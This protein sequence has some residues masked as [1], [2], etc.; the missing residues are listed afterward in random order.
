M[1]RNVA[2]ATF[3]RF[4][5]QVAVEQAGGSHVIDINF[6]SRDPEK[7]ARIANGIADTYVNAQVERKRRAAGSAASWLADRLT[8]LQ[9]AVESAE[10]A[11]AEFRATN[12]LFNSGPGDGGT[13]NDQKILDLNRQLVA[14]RAEK[15]ALEAK[16][17]QALF[18]DPSWYR[19]RLADDLLRPTRHEVGADGEP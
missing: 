19:A 6:T 3:D 15:R 17:N 13:L 12:G 9:H 18:G 7:A 8:E 2:V 1:T 4:A 5:R 14:L 11:A 16:L 10:K